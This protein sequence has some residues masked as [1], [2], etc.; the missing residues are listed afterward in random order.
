[1]HSA[2]AFTKKKPTKI[3]GEKTNPLETKKQAKNCFFQDCPVC[4][5]PLV[6]RFHYR[7]RKLK[8]RHCSGKFTAIDPLNPL[9]GSQNAADALLRRADQLL[10][11]C[12]RKLTLHAAN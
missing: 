4:G 8:C 6:I 9:I 12:S 2:S 3:K 5:R 7:G 10:E 1:M 11:Q